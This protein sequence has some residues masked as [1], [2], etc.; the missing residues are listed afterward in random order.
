[1]IAFI[2]EHRDTYGVEP[3]CK[4]LPIA[5]STYRLHAA[6]QRDPSLL[7]D[8]ARRDL[9]LM[10]E[11]ERVFETN[12]SVYGAR[13]VWRQLRRE[14]RDVA[15]CTVE[16]PMRD[17]GLAGAIGGKPVKTTVSDKGAACPLDRVNRQFQAPEPNRLWVADFTYVATWAGFVYVA[18]VIDAFAR[19]IVG[20]RVSRTAHASFVLDALE[21]AI[22][23]GS[24][25]RDRASCI[26]AIAVSNTSR[27]NTPG[28]WPKP[29]SILRSA[30]SATAPLLYGR[31]R[32][33]HCT[34]ERRPCPEPLFRHTAGESYRLREVALGDHRGGPRRKARYRG[35]PPQQNH[36]LWLGDGRLGD[37][38]FQSQGLH[39]QT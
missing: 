29:G 34:R 2:N 6:R 15:R 39:S 18:F 23:A 24:P 12:Y 8:R 36:S 16:R 21:Q 9:V 11:I 32:H 20:W 28:A 22:H 33:V 3:I 30:A 7:P 35:P 5:P 4:V 19:R 14:G 38:H 26:T 31:V 17:L 1:M 27:S 10:E 25:P 37:V 13:K